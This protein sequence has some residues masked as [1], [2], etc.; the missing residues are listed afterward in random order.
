M[1]KFINDPFNLVDEMLDGFLAVHKKKIRKLEDVRSIARTDAPV[2][3]KVGIVSGGGSGHKPAFIGFCGEGMLDAVAVGEIF[4]SPPP[5]ACYEAV[6]AANG[7]KGVLILLGNYAGDVMNFQMSADLSAADGIEVEQVILTDDVASAPKGQENRRRGVSG[8]FLCWKVAGAKAAAG[9]SLA[10]CK[11]VVE[12]VNANT[13]TIGVALSPC[14]VPAKGS[15]TFV[16]ADDEMEYGVGH[17]GE[18]G[19]ERI[20]M[21]SLDDTVQKMMNEILVDLPFTKGDNVA[22]V[23]NGLGSTPQIELYAAF[24]KVKSILDTEKIN[25]ENAYVGEFFTGLEMAGF[26]I[27]LSKLDPEIKSLL[28]APASTPCYTC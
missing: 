13:R 6:K 27:T 5:L 24:R 15:P 4:T 26:S 18:P 10:E 12:R 7:G 2:A 17:H 16:L 19:T 3:G 21:M 28:D 23:I 22:V 11:E 1:K 20:K 14:T 25:I 9:G 8:A